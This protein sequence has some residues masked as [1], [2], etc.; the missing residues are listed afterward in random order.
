MPEIV[1]S[2]TWGYHCLLLTY[3][4]ACRYIFILLHVFFFACL[5]SSGNSSLVS[6]KRS[7]MT[8]WSGPLNSCL[9]IWWLQSSQVNHPASNNDIEWW[10]MLIL[11]IV[12]CEIIVTDESLRGV[13]IVCVFCHPNVFNTSINHSSAL[14]SA[15]VILRSLTIFHIMETFLWPLFLAT[16]IDMDCFQCSCPPFL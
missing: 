4:Y 16:Q 12:R 3:L 6:V 15:V 5:N 9:V 8:W 1:G 11:V 7:K 2:L 10:M 13:T 14:A